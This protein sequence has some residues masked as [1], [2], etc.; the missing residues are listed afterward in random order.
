MGDDDQGSIRAGRDHLDIV[1]PEAVVEPLARGSR[2]GASL[3][4]V[5]DVRGAIVDVT[6]D[7]HESLVEVAD[8]ALPAQP[9]HAVPHRP[10]AE[11]PNLISIAP[12]HEVRRKERRVQH[13]TLRPAPGALGEGTCDG[14]PETEAADVEGIDLE[15]GEEVEDQIGHRSGGVT[16]LRSA[17][18]APL[19]GRSGMISVR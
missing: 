6:L 11:K 19:P 18:E 12:P 5:V 4:L 17:G 7:D 14:R 9:D 2:I 15:L 10:A 8:P 13:E 1:T 3:V 16:S